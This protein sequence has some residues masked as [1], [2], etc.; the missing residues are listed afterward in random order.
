[1]D[2][3]HQ[4]VGPQLLLDELAHDA[5]DHLGV[6]RLDVQIVE[7]DDVDAP[8]ERARVGH[9]VGLDRLGGEERPLEALDRDVHEGEGADR[10]RLP[11]LENLEVFLLEV[12]D[13]S[14]LLVGDDGVDLD[15]VD[16]ELEGRRI[17]PLRRRRIL[18][19]R[20]DGAGQQDNDPCYSHASVHGRLS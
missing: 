16:L 4:I 8:V 20:Q 9:D 7:H 5:P 19:R 15:V 11:I 18:P 10:L 14:A 13:E 2:D 6:K 17:Q 1:M 3:R 12:A